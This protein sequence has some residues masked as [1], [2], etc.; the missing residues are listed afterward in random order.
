[1]E[2]LR[3]STW[4]WYWGRSWATKADVRSSQPDKKNAV[5]LIPAQCWRW[6]TRIMWCENRWHSQSPKGHF[7]GST[8]ENLTDASFSQSSTFFIG[9]GLF[10]ALQLCSS[11]CFCVFSVRCNVWSFCKNHVEN[12]LHAHSRSRCRHLFMSLVVSK[13]TRNTRDWQHWENSKLSHHKDI[14][15]GEKAAS[16]SL[17]TGASWITFK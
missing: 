11:L 14:S 8:K 13:F 12:S 7:S 3:N 2:A 1:M 4:E 15:Y 6:G 16:F 5:P 9:D 10:T 17:E